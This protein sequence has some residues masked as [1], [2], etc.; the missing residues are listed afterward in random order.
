VGNRESNVRR[1]GVTRTIFSVTRTILG[2]GAAMNGRAP[3]LDMSGC[4]MVAS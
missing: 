4:D 2:G 1:L 3:G